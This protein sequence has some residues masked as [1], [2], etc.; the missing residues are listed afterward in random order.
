MVA[1]PVGNMVLLARELLLGA[2]VPTFNVIMVLLSTTLYAAAAVAVAANV[3]GK[4]SVVFADAGSI[5]S[6]F[7]RRLIRPAKRPSVSMSLFVVAILFPV[8]FFVQST[9]PRDVQNAAA[10]VLYG[11]ARL[12]P[13]MFVVLPV[14]ILWYW[15]VDLGNTLA[16]RWP[17]G[18]YLVAGVLLGLAAWVPAHE[19]N[20]LQM[21]W[22]GV[23]EAV[24]E[25]A[26]LLGEALKALPVGTV[27]VLIAVV[28][29]VCEEFL[30]RG[31]LLGGLRS[32]I[33][34]WPAILASAA[35]F[36]VFHFF[37]FKFP[38]TFGLGIVLAYLCWQSGSILP[39]M[40]MHLL[41]NSIGAMSVVAPEWS[42]WIGVPV[43]P[44]ASADATLSTH[45]PIHVILSGVAIC[46]IGWSVASRP[47]RLSRA[48]TLAPAAI[49][50]T[51]RG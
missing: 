4:E 10:D 21:R 23:P 16:L 34:K 29:A 11:T 42:S 32:S 12:M 39:S 25:N 50:G 47:G 17:N 33:Q 24:V 51:G 5:K 36:G 43:S 40:V 27:F 6:L 41:H 49:L 26:E 35:I 46:A 31:F 7:E 8:W 48:D 19:L 45:L 38:V 28:P 22:L 20:V 30:F 37:I 13:L 9:L 14:F 1:M 18:R 15:N 2:A 44:E 3:F